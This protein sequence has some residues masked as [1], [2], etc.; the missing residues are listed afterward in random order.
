L[1]YLDTSVIAPFYWQEHL[2]EVVQ[3]L[4]RNETEVA[5]R[6][7][8]EVELF[9][10]LSRRVRMGE[11]RSDIAALNHLQNLYKLKPL[12]SY[13]FSIACGIP[14]IATHLGLLNKA[15]IQHFYCKGS[16]I[17]HLKSIFDK[18][19]KIVF[20]VMLSFTV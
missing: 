8:V 6:Q 1:I 18:V 20:Q 3:A 10:A 19:F 2:S 17:N 11:Y 16:S 5:L 12:P 13:H 14:S 15:S 4:L 9:S 7:L